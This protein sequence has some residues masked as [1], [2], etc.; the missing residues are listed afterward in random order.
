MAAVDSPHSKTRKP[1]EA[2]ADEEGLQTRT[3]TV[4]ADAYRRLLPLRAAAL[5]GA[6]LLAPPCCCCCFS[7]A[8]ALSAAAFSPAAK[9]L[10]IAKASSPSA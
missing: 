8:A 5:S 9:V 2:A 6:P 3:Y 7:A 10:R 4:A 1:S